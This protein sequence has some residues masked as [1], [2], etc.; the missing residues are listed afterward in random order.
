VYVT[1]VK[2]F[3]QA[4]HF[5]ES[6]VVISYIISTSTLW[7]RM[8]RWYSPSNITDEEMRFGGDKSI[9]RSYTEWVAIG[10]SEFV[11]VWF[12]NS[13]LQ[14]WLLY[15]LLRSHPG[16]RSYLII[17]LFWHL[18]EYHWGIIAIIKSL[19]LDFFKKRN[20]LYCVTAIRD[21]SE[22]YWGICYFLKTFFFFFF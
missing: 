8:N 10:P 3:L 14:P 5:P 20:D 6:S 4:W 2:H 12:Q 11:Q 17:N 9:S 18:E 16:Q 22:K 7:S 13:S 15:Y 19:N 1:L 21:V